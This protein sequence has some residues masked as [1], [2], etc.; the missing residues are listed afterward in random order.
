MR[1]RSREH[2]T[3][4]NCRAR[5]I[6]RARQS[7]WILIKLSCARDRA[8]TSHLSSVFH[9]LVVPGCV[10]VLTCYLSYP[11]ELHTLIGLPSSTLWASS[12]YYRLFEDSTANPRPFVDAS[13]RFQR[14]FRPKK[15]GS[16]SQQYFELV[17]DFA[18]P[19]RQLPSTVEEYILTAI[20]AFQD[21]Y[22]C[23]WPPRGIA[24]VE[25]TPRPCS[26]PLWGRMSVSFEPWTS[27]SSFYPH[28]HSFL[29]CYVHYN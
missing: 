6:A 5:A 16:S 2:V 25:N 8:S 20:E 17:K 11:A 9:L 26:A 28:F 15:Y 10:S 14:F 24:T 27:M 12:P 21:R 13:A 18:A 23:I 7:M 19:S 22:T 3:Q 29:R 1:A 4:L